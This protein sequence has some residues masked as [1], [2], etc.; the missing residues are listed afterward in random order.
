[1]FQKLKYILFIP[2]DL[3]LLI[4]GICIYKLT[5]QT[6]LF[7]CNQYRLF[8]I[9]GGVNTEFTNDLTKSKIRLLQYNFKENNYIADNIRENG[10]FIKEDFLT[11]DEF[12]D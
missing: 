3:F 7:L 12:K 4:L 11:F 1:M 10:L 6:F 9:F 2:L 5:K 8:Y